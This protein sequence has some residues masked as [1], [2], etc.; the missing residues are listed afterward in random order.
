MSAQSDAL[1]FSDLKFGPAQFSDA[2]W[3]V[4][5]CLYTNTCQI[6]GLSG[7]GT[8]WN[9]GY[10]VHIGST[11]YI[12]FSPSSDPSY[13]WTMNLYNSNGSLAQNLGNGKLAIQGQD[14][15]AHYFFFFVNSNLNGTVFSLNYGFPNSSGFSFTGTGNPT[16]PQTNAIAA[17]GSSVPLAPGQTGG[18]GAAPPAP[19]VVS[20]TNTTVITTTT[21]GTTVYTY[22][23]PVTITNYSDGSHTQTNIGVPTLISIV[24]TG[25][26]NATQSYVNSVTSFATRPSQ[27]SK[28]QIQQI[29]DYNNIAIEQAGTKNNFVN[30]SGNGN[31]NNIEVTQTGIASSTNYTDVRVGG[32]LSSSNNTV[33]VQQSSTGG[34][35]GAFINVQDN[36]NNISVKQQ[37]SG[38]HWAEVTVS[39]GNKSVDITQSGAAGHMASVTLTGPQAVGV[40]LQQTGNT[41]Q[42]YS[43]QSNC[44]TPGGCGTISVTQGR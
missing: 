9:L 34:A 6:Y 14:D 7:I 3:N 29:G 25:Q 22:R 1:Q 32:V 35:K 24:N 27:D 21:S 11:Q 31:N 43:I 33:N 12:Q 16:V 5:A 42:F 20:T 17:G 44:T 28:V 18:A 38:N 36:N 15:N 13:P 41:Q 30:Y 4:G 23:Q 8:S 39:G 26:F 40:N 10:P 19:T 37:D 2:Q